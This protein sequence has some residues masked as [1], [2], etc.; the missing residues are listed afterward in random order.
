MHASDEPTNVYITAL[1]DQGVDLN[2]QDTN[3]GKLIIDC[4]NVI[5]NARDSD[6]V[7]LIGVVFLIS[8]RN[9]VADFCV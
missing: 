2:A 1:N 5:D 9:N 3:Q 8:P 7:P 4:L 6:Q